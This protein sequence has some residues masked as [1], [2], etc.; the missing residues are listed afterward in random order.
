[1]RVG[2]V[3][4]RSTP[5][6]VG[7][8]L[9]KAVSWIE[10]IAESAEL[11]V[12]PELFNV[13]YVWETK[14]KQRVEESFE[15]TCEILSSIADSYGVHIFAGIGRHENGKIYNSVGHFSPLNEPEFYDKT[16][17]FRK[18][19]EIFQAGNRLRTFKVG[20]ITV[21]VF[22]CYEVGFPEIARTLALQGSEIFVVPFAFAS[23]R[24]TIYELA[25]RSRA[26]ENGTFLVSAC[27]TGKGFFNFY[28]HS[29]IVSPTGEVLSD[30][31]NAEGVIMTEIDTSSVKR[32]RYEELPDS[33][34][35][36]ANFRPELYERIKDRR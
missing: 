35:Y 14:I 31:G 29:R 28:G 19:R 11:V 27:Q 22:I 5:Y 24:A 9:E 15:E 30:A 4:M 25:T 13:G 1:M 7:T 10:E 23:E 34:A 12:L 21:G 20:N 36:F 6:N 26:L 2:V 3:Q 17:L 32:Y 18:E 16:H 33:H 8:N